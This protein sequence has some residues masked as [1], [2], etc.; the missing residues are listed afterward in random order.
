M[1]NYLL[2]INEI[3]NEQVN[4]TKL[5]NMDDVI[6]EANSGN[7][8]L[9]EQIYRASMIKVYEH[10]IGFDLNNITPDKDFL[11][12]YSIC[13]PKKG[14]NVLRDN[15]GRIFRT[16]EELIKHLVKIHN[17]STEITGTPEISL[18]ELNK[19]YQTTQEQNMEI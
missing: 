10:Y 16:R 19:L 13:T 1:I 8:T 7:T 2:M 12:R 17:I 18:E 11:L 14:R 4:N 6:N 3:N 5:F 9:L 15:I